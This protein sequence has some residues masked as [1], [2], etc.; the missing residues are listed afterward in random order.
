MAN[1]QGRDRS[2]KDQ[3]YKLSRFVLGP[4]CCSLEKNQVDLPPKQTK[5]DDIADAKEFEELVQLLEKY[6]AGQGQGFGPMPEE[7]QVQ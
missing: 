3:T 6:E 1:T 2:R 5:M 4:S 7:L